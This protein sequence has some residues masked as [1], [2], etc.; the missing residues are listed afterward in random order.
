MEVKGR[1]VIVTGASSGIGE[2]TAR[3]FAKEGAKVV[4]AARRVDRLESLARD[5]DATCRA[6]IPPPS[7]GTTTCRPGGPRV[8][9]NRTGGCR[10]ASL[11]LSRPASIR[12][13]PNRNS[14]A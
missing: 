3:E 11:S 14:L 2:A 10:Q 7:L 1:I 4:L 5:I 8:D 6:R 12:S 13:S 9:P